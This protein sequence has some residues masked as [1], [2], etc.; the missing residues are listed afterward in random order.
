MKLKEVCVP[1]LRAGPALQIFS[2]ELVE[3]TYM[4]TVLY[5]PVACMRCGPCVLTT[6]NGTARSL[7]LPGG[8]C[9]VGQVR[10]SYLYRT[11]ER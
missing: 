1:G 10:I 2:A 8:K 3:P 6:G 9:T 7:A 11:L 4:Y 5:L